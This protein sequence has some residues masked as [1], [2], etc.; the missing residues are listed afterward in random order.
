MA[1]SKVEIKKYEL[2]Y[3]LSP[4]VS[5]ENLAAT[6]Q[7]EIIAP[8][9]ALGGEVSA[10]PL[11]SMKSLAYPIKKDI[12]NKKATFKDAYFGYVHFSL[13]PNDAVKLNQTLAK[14]DL[15]VRVLL[16][17]AI[18]TI[19]K[20]P[21]ALPAKEVKTEVKA[22]ADAMPTEEVVVKEVNQEEIDREIEGL[23]SQVG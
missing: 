9:T 13:K 16:I 8:I 7:S 12:G 10:S 17:L 21:K 6:V 1:K 15:L 19:G 2:G 20:K 11:P 3:L 4:L 22:P 5:A 23:L 18:R 14:S